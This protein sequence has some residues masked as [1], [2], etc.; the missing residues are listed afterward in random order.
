MLVYQQSSE[1]DELSGMTCWGHFKRWRRRN[2]PDTEEGQPAAEGDLIVVTNPTMEME[3]F[4][5]R[6][7]TSV[8][9]KCDGEIATV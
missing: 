3:G 1:T 6:K 7:S 5:H 2:E 8:N 4:K 9:T